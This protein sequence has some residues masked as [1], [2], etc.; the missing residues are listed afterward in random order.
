MEQRL[1]GLEDLGL[2]LYVDFL[3]PEEEHALVTK[4]DNIV[5][6]R[7]RSPED[8]ERTS[9]SRFGSSLPY[10]SH[11]QSKFIPDYLVQYARK[12]VELGLLDAQPDS[13]S[14]N[15]Y[16]RGQIIVPHI[17]SKASGKV[18]TVLSLKT[19]ATM[20]FTQA[21]NTFA[22]LVELPPCS[23][24]Q[25]RGEIRDLWQHEILPVPGHR[26]SVVFRCSTMY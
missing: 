5:T 17:D 9:I 8:I 6:R 19:P 12:L 20:R 14:I 25:M 18:I 10:G 13:V 7:Q 23:L 24:V 22:H 16:S 4:I 15:E 26:Y 11:M 1:T 21:N 3:T 2:A